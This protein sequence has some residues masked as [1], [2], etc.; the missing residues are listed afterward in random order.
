MF[1]R[2]V[3]HEQIFIQSRSPND[4]RQCLAKY[5]KARP[6]PRKS[7]KVDADRSLSPRFLSE[8]SR[9]YRIQRQRSQDDHWPTNRSTSRKLRLTFETPHDRTDAPEYGCH[10]LY[11]PFFTPRT[12]PHEVS[13]TAIRQLGYP[14]NSRATSTG[15]S[16]GQSF[17]GNRL[18]RAGRNSRSAIRAAPRVVQ[19]MAAK[20]T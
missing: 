18:S 1:Q 15:I 11:C 20:F 10:C 19:P 5:T 3:Y 13:S 2:G 4:R 6:Q 8:D 12:S 7:A 17:P 14:E 9:C 16:A